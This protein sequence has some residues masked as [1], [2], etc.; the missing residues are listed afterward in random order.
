MQIS[1]ECLCSSGGRGNGKAHAAAIILHLAGDG[2]GMT[3]AVRIGAGEIPR[4]GNR[5]FNL[6]ITLTVTIIDLP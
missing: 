5:S 3:A 1:G 2:T 6:Q 4:T